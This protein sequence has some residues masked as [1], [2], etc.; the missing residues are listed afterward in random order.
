MNFL[1]NSGRTDPRIRTVKKGEEGR[2]RGEIRGR[3]EEK[4][5]KN[6]V[7][8]GRDEERRRRRGR[9]DEDDYKK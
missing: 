1:S 2:N 7:G 9:T 4:K 8:G 6:N 5:K 3:K